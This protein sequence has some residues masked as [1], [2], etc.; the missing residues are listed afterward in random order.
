MRRLKCDILSWIFNA[1]SREYL[2]AVLELGELRISDSSLY[3][4]DDY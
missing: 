4:R 2:D 1:P 3:F